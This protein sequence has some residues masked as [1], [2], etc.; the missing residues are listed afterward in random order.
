MSNMIQNLKESLMETVMKLL[1]LAKP[2][3][4]DGVVFVLGI[5]IGHLLLAL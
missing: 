2:T 1:K 3:K 5:V 4:R